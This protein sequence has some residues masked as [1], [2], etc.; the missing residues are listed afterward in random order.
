VS[1][2]PADSAFS[3]IFRA[4]FAWGIGTPGRRITKAAFGT[5]RLSPLV[6]AMFA[7]RSE[8]RRRQRGSAMMGRREDRQG[9]IRCL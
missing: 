7:K 3:C 5:K 6:H 9:S 4:R 8:P 1:G 2:W